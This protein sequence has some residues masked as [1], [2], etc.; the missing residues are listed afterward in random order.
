MAQKQAKGG[1]PRD[2][3]QEVGL[4]IQNVWFLLFF[5]TLMILIASF[6]LIAEA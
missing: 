4:F 1:Q 2:N 3:E 5:F 6:G